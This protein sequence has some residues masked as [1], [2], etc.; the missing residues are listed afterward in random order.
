M[1]CEVKWHNERVATDYSLPPPGAA[2]GGVEVRP[3]MPWRT[4][5]AMPNPPADFSMS[6]D[7][8]AAWLPSGQSIIGGP[9]LA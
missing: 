9:Y 3:L 5:K 4:Y 1:A 7:L 8:Q 2:L 6:A